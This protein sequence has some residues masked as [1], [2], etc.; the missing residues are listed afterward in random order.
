MWSSNVIH[1][2]KRENCVVSNLIFNL[3]VRE[4]LILILFYVNVPD[5]VL[6]G[7]EGTPFSGL[8]ICDFSD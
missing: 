2:F 7:S 4:W 5:Y 1:V 8:A 6:E 3:F